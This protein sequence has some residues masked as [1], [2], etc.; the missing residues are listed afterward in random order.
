MRK[1]NEQKPSNMDEL[2]NIK[3]PEVQQPQEEP[4]PKSSN[5]AEAFLNMAEEISNSMQNPGEQ[6]AP[7]FTSGQSQPQPQPEPEQQLNNEKKEV[8][9]NLNRTTS[10]FKMGPR[11]LEALEL[12]TNVADIKS[13]EIELPLMKT[14]AIVK[15]LTGFEEQA[16]RTASAS[17]ETFLKKFNEIL[18]DHTTFDSIRFNSFQEFLAN[19]Q[20]PDRSML[21]F[22]LMMSSYMVLPEIQKECP[23]CGHLNIIKK[24]PK[25]LFHPDTIKKVW[26]KPLPPIEYTEIQEVLNGY[27]TFELG[28]PTEL[29]R[30]LVLRL[31]SNNDIGENMAQ[32]GELMTFSETLAFFTKKITVNTGNEV[33]VLTDLVQDIYPFLTKIPPKIGDAIKSSIDLTI[34]D[35]YMP[36]FYLENI[37]ENCGATD[38]EEV[39]IEMLFFRKAM[40]I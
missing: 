39:D 7:N 12:V 14:R 29:S 23:K 18:F 30:L 17:P 40:D 10:S 27:L 5:N 16:L 34:F 31:M 1:A 15:P 21:I 6:P 19:I 4:T 3:Q 24:E 28:V 22:G 8:E 25:D 33:I 38:K 35:D 32:T 20:M 26:D 37:C 13:F 9:S 11:Y 2:F 36:D